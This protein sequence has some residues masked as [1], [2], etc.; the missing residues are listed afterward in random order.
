MERYLRTSEIC[1]RLGVG[2]ITIFRWRRAG[3]FPEPKILG[4]G[5]I[6]WPESV[7]R[8][9]QESRPSAGTVKP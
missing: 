1:E 8:E 2:R 5:T 3:L 9:W 4:P 6:G 7:I